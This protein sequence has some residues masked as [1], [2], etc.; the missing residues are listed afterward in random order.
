MS[1]TSCGGKS[2]THLADPIF[3]SY[4]QEMKKKRAYLVEGTGGSMPNDDVRT[5]FISFIAE[6]EVDTTQARRL[7]IEVVNGFIKKVNDDKTIRPYLHD[8]PVTTK[9][10]EIFLSFVDKNTK[11]SVADP[12]ISFILCYNDIIYYN[13]YDK[14][15]REFRSVYQEPYEVALK[16]VQD[17]QKTIQTP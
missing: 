15:I 5:F 6:Y 11:K 13:I 4:S 7:Y 14:D 8:Y 2:Y 16:I 9:N 3:K 12:L 10:M 1:I 17:E